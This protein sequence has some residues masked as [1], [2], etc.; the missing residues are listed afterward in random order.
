[1]RHEIY[2][3]I[4]LLTHP[5]TMYGGLVRMELNQHRPWFVPIFARYSI[6][7]LDSVAN[8]SEQ[9]LV[10]ETQCMRGH[11]FLTK[12]A[13]PEFATLCRFGEHI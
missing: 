13:S 4:Y 7:L 10:S 6:W 11:S 3:V 5:L 9:A 12:E 2:D 1:M 8:S